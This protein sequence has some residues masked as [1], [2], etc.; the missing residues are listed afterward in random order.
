MTATVIHETKEVLLPSDYLA[1]LREF[2]LCLPQFDELFGELPQVRVVID[3]N[4]VFGELIYRLKNKRNANARS[5]LHEVIAARTVIAY[6]PVFICTEVEANIPK[7]A[8]GQGISENKLREEWQEIKG[9]LHFYEPQAR[10]D[11]HRAEIVDPKDLPYCDLWAEIGAQGVCSKDKHISR[12]GVPIITVD[13]IIALRGY[14]RAASVEVGIKVCG[15]TVVAA[16]IG[17]L[18]GMLVLLFAA[19][20]GFSRLPAAAKL[21]FASIAA[22]AVAHP[23]SRKLIKTWLSSAFKHLGETAIPILTSASKSFS[24]AER[25]KALCWEAAGKKLP[26][27]KRHPARTHLRAVCVA[28]KKPLSL[29]ELERR[30]LLAGYVTRAKNLR[31]YLKRI[32]QNDSSF[33]QVRAGYWVILRS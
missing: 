12:M 14:S 4:V 22:I 26:V 9:L 33:A 28:A 10:I 8:R 23:S 21:A 18:R 2:V 11:R 20:R 31:V 1:V 25:D 7:V 32:L 30:V 27:G 29:L 15:V 19:G 3:A 5:Y 16:G 13:A 24:V 6:A 17:L